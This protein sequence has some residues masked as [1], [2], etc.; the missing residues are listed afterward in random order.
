[1]AK[2]LILLKHKPD[3]YLNRIRNGE[4]Y[5]AARY[6][7]GEWITITRPDARQ[8]NCDG[9]AMY[10][11]MAA[12][13]RKALKSHPNYLL[14]MQ[15]FALRLM[16]KEIRAWIAKNNLWDLEWHIADHMA[17][18]SI[19]SK[20]K[21]H[22]L[23]DALREANVLIVGPSHLRRL[24]PRGVV[25][26]LGFIDV[27]KVNAFLNLNRIAKAVQDAY[28]KLPKP[29]VISISCG[30]PAGLLVDRLFPVLGHDAF[31]LDMGSVFDNHCG[32]FSRSYMKQ[33]RK[34]GKYKYANTGSSK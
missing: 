6:G 31:L 3:F 25:N 2:E 7:D 24:K 32:V 29:L 34:E 20:G 8:H 26:F 13:Y 10:P 21:F 19:N 33:L 12:Q 30:L 14:G 27:P 15:P 17:M 18:H 16:G 11:K 4:V 5:S 23:A 28:S 22:Q 1:M 9:H